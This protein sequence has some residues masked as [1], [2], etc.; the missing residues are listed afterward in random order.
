MRTIIINNPGPQGAIGPQ[1][2]QG[3]PGP[4]PFIYRHDF[5]VFDYIGKA[6]S[7]SLEADNVWDITRLTIASSGSVTVGTATNVNW[8]GRYTHTYS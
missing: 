8:T 5:N 1:G 4:A 2:P 3:P 6:P 7:G